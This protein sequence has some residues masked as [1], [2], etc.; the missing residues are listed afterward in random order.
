MIKIDKDQTEGYPYNEED[1]L[2]EAPSPETQGDEVEESVGYEE[3]A[4]NEE[5]KQV[6][7]EEAMLTPRDTQERLQEIAEIIVDEKWTELTSRLGNLALWKNRVDTDITAIK[8]EI[9]RTQ[10]RI[11]NLQNAMIGKLNEYNRNIV[12]ISSEMK[13]LDKVL[14]NIIE[15][16]TTNI[17][18]LSKITSKLKSK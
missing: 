8:Q 9:F 3:S 12:T 5:P 11:E 13:A 7:R 10:N 15:P 2:S 18:E 17:K 16:L 14:Q 4:Y 6:R 1:V